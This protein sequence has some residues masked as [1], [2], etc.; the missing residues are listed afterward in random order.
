MTASESRG[1]G[2][3][4]AAAQIER[5]DAR[6]AHSPTEVLT[7]KLRGP[8][9]EECLDAAAIAVDAFNAGAEARG[10]SC[11]IE[12]FPVELGFRIRSEAMPDVFVVATGREVRAFC[13][14]AA[15]AWPEEWQG[16]RV[17]LADPADG[18]EAA[19]WQIVECGEDHPDRGRRVYG[20]RR[21]RHEADA[22][23]SG[24]LH[25]A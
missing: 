19:V 6:N 12:A 22:F 25:A 21:S 9:P 14:G 7:A 17:R 1:S 15:A 2:R 24:M 8:H 20:A 18:A 23:A 3:T 13:D 11:R 10:D 5:N 4:A 16:V